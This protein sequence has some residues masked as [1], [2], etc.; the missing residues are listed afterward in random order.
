MVNKQGYTHHLS[1]RFDILHKV[2]DIRR[3]SLFVARRQYINFSLH[4]KK[5][6]LSY[7]MFLL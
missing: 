6:R 4:V 2:L 1:R 5:L 7:S 3:H